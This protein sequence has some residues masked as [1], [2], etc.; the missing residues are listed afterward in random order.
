MKFFKRGSMMQEHRPRQASQR[1]SRRQLDKP[2]QFLFEF[3]LDIVAQ[4][5]M[6]DL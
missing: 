6:I 1:E 2:A 5:L 3:H 4:T